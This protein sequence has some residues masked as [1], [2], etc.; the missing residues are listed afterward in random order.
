[1]TFLSLVHIADAGS[2]SGA[3][4]RAQ[5]QFTVAVVIDSSVNSEVINIS[6]LFPV[7]LYNVKQSE[8]AK[9]TSLAPSES[10]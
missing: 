9:A 7:C 1:M 6:R 8:R 5:G 10:P 3:Q 4:A 2:D